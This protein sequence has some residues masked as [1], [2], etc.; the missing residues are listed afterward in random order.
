VGPRESRS[1]KTDA[2]LNLLKQPEGASIVDITKATDWQPHSVRAFLSATVA[3][4]LGHTVIS[5]KPTFGDRRY[6]IAEPEARS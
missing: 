6:R 1:S 3:K 4:R 5:E 2:I